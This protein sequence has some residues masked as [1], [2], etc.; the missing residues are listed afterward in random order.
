MKKKVIVLFFS[1]IFLLQ[2]AVKASEDPETCR[3]LLPGGAATHQ[4][5]HVPIMIWP[6][7]DLDTCE[8]LHVFVSDGKHICCDPDKF[9]LDNW[10]YAKSLLD[11]LQIGCTITNI[12]SLNRYC[13]N[14]SLIDARLYADRPVFINFEQAWQWVIGN[15]PIYVPQN[16]EFGAEQKMAIF[17]SAS[18][19]FVGCPAE[20]FFDNN[21]R[22][23][24]TSIDSHICY[25]YTLRQLHDEGYTIGYLNHN[26][27][28]HP[29]SLV[30]TKPSS[31]FPDTK[32]P[33][34]P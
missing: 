32:R 25:V 21:W 7:T 4:L 28:L 23:I 29:A 1:L 13:P 30:P 24:E 27:Y 10:S 20:C 19:Q 31:G 17:R 22:A 12:E 14:I 2:S 16:L 11:V 6:D 9:G 33:R 18:G 3:D 5:Q 8:R 26:S 34:F 15:Q